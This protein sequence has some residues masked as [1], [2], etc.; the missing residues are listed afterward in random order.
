M[1]KIKLN[2]EVL[3]IAGKDKGKKGKVMSI[4]FKTNRIVV[5]GVNRI[6]KALKPTQEN[7]TGGFSEMEKGIHI[8]NISMMSPKTGNATRVKIEEKDG[9]K[10]RVATKCGSVLN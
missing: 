7:P 6:K 8:S 3:V 2:D 10:I 1:Q 9:K 4:N 5:E